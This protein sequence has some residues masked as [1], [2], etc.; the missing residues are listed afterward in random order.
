M[1]VARREAEEGAPEGTLVLAE[2]QTNGYGYHQPAWLSPPG[3][4]YFSLVLHPDAEA[5]RLLPLTASVAVAGA[6]AAPGRHV[7]TRWPG[8]IVVD[9][10]TVGGVLVKSELRAER[11]LFAVLGIGLRLD[12]AAR[13]ARERILAA[14]LNRLESL[15]LSAN[16]E[17]VLFAYRAYQAVGDTVVVHDRADYVGTVE[18]I[19]G[20]GRLLVF[21]GVGEVMA[22]SYA[23]DLVAVAS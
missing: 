5:L 14:T 1:N 13:Q 11:P 23:V 9:G 19:D 2:E 3:N 22:T 6:L 12:A 21:D 16:S 20:R 7:Q 18:G 10:E 15:L 4:L 17:E 8:D